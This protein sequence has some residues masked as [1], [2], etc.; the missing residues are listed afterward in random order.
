MKARSVKNCGNS[1]SPQLNG[2]PRVN[3]PPVYNPFSVKSTQ[4]Y[5]RHSTPTI[6]R[7]ALELPQAQRKAPISQ[8]PGGIGL[9]GP[10]VY[11]PF[12]AQSGQARYSPRF[13]AGTGVRLDSNIS[14]RGPQPACCIVQRMEELR[15]AY[16]S[17]SD[18]EDEP[19]PTPL[20]AST[21][22]IK[23]SSQPG[24]TASKSGGMSNADFRKLLT[25][26]TSSS[27]GAQLGSCKTLGEMFRFI[28]TYAD[29]STANLEEALE[30][31]AEGSHARGFKGLKQRLT[32]SG[33]EK[34]EIGHEMAAYNTYVLFL[35]LQQKSKNRS[36]WAPLVEQC[37][38]SGFDH[39]PNEDDPGTQ[40][41]WGGVRNAPNNKLGLK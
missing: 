38:E 37:K 3:W 30:L 1:V 26:K 25:E 36:K 18:D 7:R 35:R 23:L 24:P 27:L 5:P 21:S 41:G 6:G 28:E 20:P 12:G 11:D 22:E 40:R 19:K 10:P 34:K 17:G 16:G 8:F 2:H 9:I 33:F 4:L 29:Q 31:L 14:Y 39:K 15:G 13:P 32:P